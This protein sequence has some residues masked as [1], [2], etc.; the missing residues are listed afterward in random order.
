MTTSCVQKWRRLVGG[1]GEARAEECRGRDVA[2]KAGA[3]AGT[4]RVPAGRRDAQRNTGRVPG[5]A[6]YWG[7]P[8]TSALLKTVWLADSLAPCPAPPSRMPDAAARTP[9]QPSTLHRALFINLDPPS[10]FGITL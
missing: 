1:C 4:A 5:E 8:L 7:E 3:A 2:R 6:G 9:P 10:T